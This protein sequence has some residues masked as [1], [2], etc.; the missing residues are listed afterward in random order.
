MLYSGLG[1]GD[2][3]GA[4]EADGEGDGEGEDVVWAMLASPVTT[5]VIATANTAPQRAT[6][7]N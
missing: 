2:D 1:V 7:T 4:G 6:L 3:D 5:T